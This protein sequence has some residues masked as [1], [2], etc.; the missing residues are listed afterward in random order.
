MIRKN[1]LWVSR[2]LREEA[3]SLF[4]RK[5]KLWVLLPVNWVW[6]SWVT[7]WVFS[8]SWSLAGPSHLPGTELLSLLSRSKMVMNLLYE[9]NYWD[10]LLCFPVHSLPVPPPPPPHPPL[11]LTPQCELRAP[12]TRGP[13]HISSG[14]HCFL[15]GLHTGDIHTSNS[16]QIPPLDNM[17]LLCSAHDDITVQLLSQNPLGLY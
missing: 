11:T 8:A 10:I 6:L 2:R 9:A 14:V 12:S 13:Y 4:S 16:S 15:C 1:L 3:I 17:S 5:A 7:F